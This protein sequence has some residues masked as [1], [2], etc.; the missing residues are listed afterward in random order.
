MTRTDCALSG[1]QFYLDWLR[2]IALALLVLFHVGMYYVSWP[3]HIKSPNP[4]VDL[5]LWMRLLSPWRMDLLFLISGAATAM[6]LQQ[7]GAGAALLRERASRL[8]VPLVFGMLVVVPPQSYLEVLQ[9]FGYQ[10]SYAEFIRLYLG[11]FGGFCATGRG[12]LILPT[13]NHLWYL[14]YLFAYTAALW[15]AVRAWPGLLDGLARSMSLTLR[16][17]GLLIW[18]VLFL[19]AT[20][21][22][23]QARFPVTY[24]LVGDWFAHSQYLAMFFF[25]AAFVRTAKFADRIEQW[26]VVALACAVA[27]GVLLSAPPAWGAWR[28]VG[29][30][31]AVLHAA[32]YG[33]L[34]WCAIIAAVGFARRHLNVD[35]AARRYLTDAVFPVYV[36]HQSLT[37]VLAHGLLRFA[38]APAVEAPL[39][40]GATFA[41]SML[42]YEGVRRV[43]G[44]RPL[45]GLAR[46]APAVTGAQNSRSSPLTA[47]ATA[48]D[49]LRSH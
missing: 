40:V 19:A 18:P 16:G 26:R 35:C 46:R 27:A 1:R 45:F 37:I 2:I 31:G 8:L 20:R 24:A 12:C 44:L 43:G 21:W 33:S 42:G 41:L 38:L 47:R 22:A 39:L 29:A 23:L 17:A 5:E 9:R 3:W 25:G 7:R 14:P 15:L 36:L 48:T 4:V 30:P 34:Q 13:W 6:M 28:G 10:G 32:L 49:R 11:G